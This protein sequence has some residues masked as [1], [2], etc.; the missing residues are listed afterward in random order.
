MKTEVK[1]LKKE[2]R[3]QPQPSNDIS[4]VDLANKQTVKNILKRLND[5]EQ[6]LNSMPIPSS[7]GNPTITKT[8]SD[9]DKKT[10]SMSFSKL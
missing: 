2:L 9:L 7:S 4:D 3:N 6:K 1:K 8:I 10:T 5:M